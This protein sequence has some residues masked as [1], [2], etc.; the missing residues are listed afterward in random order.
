MAINNSTMQQF[1]NRIYLDNAATTK[2]DPE[3]I[4]VMSKIN[5]ETFGN[6][7]SLHSFGTEAKDILS[8]SRKTIANFLGCNEREVVFTSGGSESDN[9]AIRGIIA[10]SKLQIAKKESKGHKLSAIS[11]KPHIVTT[12]IEHHAVLHTIEQ[13]EKEGAVEATYVKPEADG[14][15]DAKKIVEAIKDN[16]V[17]VSVVYVNNETGAVQPIAEIGKALAQLNEERSIANAT[18]GSLDSARDDNQNTKYKIRN[19]IY[20]HTDAVQAAEWFDLN[21]NKLGVDLLTFTAH[22]FHGPKGIGALYA[23]QGLKIKPQITGG[24]HEWGVRAGTENVAS[25]AGMAKAIEEVQSYKVTK[26]QSIRKLKDKLIDKLFKIPDSR[27]NGSR[28]KSS[29]AIANISFYNAEGEAILMNLDFLGIAV[30][31]GSACSS[32]SLNPSHV[33]TAM[34]VVPEWAHGSVRFSLSR[35]TTEE[36]IDKVLEVMPGIID[37]LRKMSPFK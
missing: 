16:T 29:P 14:V 31:T 15:V 12:A 23:R 26:L 33:L 2:V 22:K 8:A 25:I 1:N 7:S 11:H 30:S 24:S 5:A 32:K 6:A 13:L 34:G 37:R 20:F 17:L 35:D 19:T 28:D 36:E 3:V 10:N 18:V 4:K 9:L 27:L 21:V